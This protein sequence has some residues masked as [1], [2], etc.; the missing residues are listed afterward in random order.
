MHCFCRQGVHLAVSDVTIVSVTVKIVLP[1]KAK[2][3]RRVGKEEVQEKLVTLTVAC[4]AGQ[5]SHPET[6]VRSHFYERTRACS[7]TPYST[8]FTFSSPVLSAGV[9]VTYFCDAFVS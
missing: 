5:L 2:C 8:W 6:L 1:Y 3:V 7:H 4:A 9:C